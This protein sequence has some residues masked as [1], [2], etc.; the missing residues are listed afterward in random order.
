MVF[1]T[2]HRLSEFSD[3]IKARQVVRYLKTDSQLDNTQTLAFVV[4]PDHVHWLLILN[5]GTLPNAVQRIKSMYSRYAQNKI[6]NKGFYDHGI[7][8]DEDLAAVAR[9]IV[10]NPLR[11]NLVK[12]VG[13]YPHWDAVWL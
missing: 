6:W 8:G 9:Y 10:A 3:F 13:D 2:K 7:R 12:R 1:S 4:M 11:A 5:N